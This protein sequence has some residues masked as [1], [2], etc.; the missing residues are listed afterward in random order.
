VLCL[1]CKHDT[2]G[3]KSVEHIIPES[4]GNTKSILPPGVVCDGCNNYFAR[5][6]EKPLLDS[7]DL[8]A[9][10]FHQRVSNKRGR[11]PPLQGTIG[12]SAPAAMYLHNSGTFAGLLDVSPEALRLIQDGGAD[13]LNLP[14]PKDSWDPTLTSRFLAKIALESLAS[15]LLACYGGSDYAVTEPLLDRIRVYARRGGAIPW[16]YYRRRI[17]DA[18]KPWTLAGREVVQR[19][20]E[21]E[22]LETERAEHYFILA[23]FGLELTINY[24]EPDIRGYTDWLHRHGGVS[25]L[26]YGPNATHPENGILSRPDFRG[27]NLLTHADQVSRRFVAPVTSKT[28]LSDV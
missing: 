4:L 23:L 6:V 2:T 21:W 17:Y 24:H 27:R 22:I 8:T 9:L 20:W 13:I 14:A 7:L 16:P 26:Y 5:K 19:V 3:S 28:E 25:P 10:R 15:R 18:D 1:F 11:I 12:P